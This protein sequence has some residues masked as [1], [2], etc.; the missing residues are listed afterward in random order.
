MAGQRSGLAFGL[1]AFFLLLISPL[2]FV[3]TAHA[4][5]TEDMGTVIGI[6]GHPHLTHDARAELT[7]RRISVPPTAASV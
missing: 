6:V 1:L 7:R 4:E 2:A 5:S 3:Q